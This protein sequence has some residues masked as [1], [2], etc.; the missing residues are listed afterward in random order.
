MH[1]ILGIALAA[2]LFV[3]LRQWGTL[4]P[5]KKKAATW[6]AILIGGGGLLLLM[7]LTGRIHVLTAAVAALLPLLRKLPALLKYLPF[8]QRTLNGQAGN[9]KGRN[10]QGSTDSEER[11]WTGADVA[12]QVSEREA[13]EILGVE[14]GCNR[15]EI[16]MAHRRL[17]QKIHPDRGGNDYLAAK[18]N[19]AKRVLLRGA[20]T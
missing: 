11:Q 14:P 9:G 2:G 16:V 15:D 13:C 19:E 8:I 3:V 18:V 1:W 17:M 4:S 12:G 10:N 5:E 7:V 20:K 6:K